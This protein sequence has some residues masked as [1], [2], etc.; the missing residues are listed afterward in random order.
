MFYQ[1]R[2]QI[3]KKS[4]L[5]VFLNLI[6]LFS[7][8]QHFEWAASATNIDLRYS[9]ASIDINNNIVVGGEGVR[10]YTHREKS[11]IFDG[12][13]IAVNIDNF[14][15]QKETIISYSTTGNI[16]W[17]KT[18]DSRYV[19]LYGISHTNDN[20]VLL[21][22][23]KRSYYDKSNNKSYGIIPELNIERDD[24]I[25][26]GYYL[27]FL[28]SEGNLLRYSFIFQD[29]KID[30]SSFVSYNNK[31]FLI[32]GFANPGKILENFPNEAG[33]G[34]GDFLMMID[35]NGKV[36]WLEIISYKK[37][38]CCSY[39]SNMCKIA[40]A[41]NGT[42]Y[43]GGTYYEGG[44]FGNTKTIVSPNNSTE[45]KNRP[46][47]AYVA[48]YTAEG[49]LLWV[50]TS[51]QKASFS[52]IAANNNGVFISY[53]L[54]FTNTAFKNKFDTTFNKSVVISH[55]DN[56]GKLKW[57]SNNNT[58]QIHDI[59]TDS[60]N[61]IY[62]LGTS[63]YRQVHNI[64]GNDTLKKSDKVYIARFSEKGQ[65]QW[66]KTANI[67]ITTQNEPFNFFMDNCN[68]FYLTGTLWFV[69]PAN[70]SIWDKAF[71]KGTGYGPAPLISRFNNT[72]PESVAERIMNENK[73]KKESKKDIENT[74][75]IISPGPWKIRNYPNPF[76]DNTTI[77]FT[78]S[79]SDYITIDIFDTNG[80]L[81][82]NLISDMKYETGTHTVKFSK[83]LSSGLYIAGLKG[84]AA[85]ASCMLSVSK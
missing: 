75:C 42:I 9:F 34:G 66:I 68:N 49:K 3:L 4:L 41:P 33:K 38:T 7:F 70:M 74:I 82:M 8:S 65:Y 52:S 26:S 19:K 73:V 20:T 71:L 48:A 80:K 44:V 24:L 36:N 81:I 27:I 60:D 14:F 72:I 17:S 64:V 55:F 16:N 30:I 51:I 32:S 37:E 61:N 62:I 5:L 46:Y 18:L 23:L 25:E 15:S 21:L 79:Y 12:S 1:M 29:K 45:T 11:E 83:P 59:K 6:T 57:S 58:D 28:N 78:L 56:K 39:F 85:Y 31:G 47:E 40:V 35:L 2:N 69:L 50:E 67:P 53:R 22:H 13:G 77:E 54:N 43:L 76:T 84:T 10:N 63:S